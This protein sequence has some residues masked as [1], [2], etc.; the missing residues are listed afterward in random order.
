MRWVLDGFI[1]VLNSAGERKIGRHFILTGEAV[2]SASAT[3]C[4]SK[5]IRWSTFWGFEF[6]G[7]RRLLEIMAKQSKLR[8]LLGEEVPSVGVARFN[9]VEEAGS[10]VVFSDY[11]WRNK[12]KIVES[13]NFLHS[14]IKKKSSASI[15]LKN[16]SSIKV[17]RTFFIESYKWWESFKKIK[18]KWVW[19][20]ATFLLSKIVLLRNSNNVL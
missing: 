15:Q 7:R 4:K 17:H 14:G 16:R 2:R 8:G 19:F 18:T 10:D 20:Y 5:I 1:Y 12:R 9:S 11:I 13:A 6:N 3:L